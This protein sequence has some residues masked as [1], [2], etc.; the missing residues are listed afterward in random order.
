LGAR[1]TAQQL[2]ALAVFAEAWDS[3]SSIHKAYHLLWSSRSLDTQQSQNTQ[4]YKK[5]KKVFFKKRGFHFLP[6]HK[7][8]VQKLDN[9]HILN[10]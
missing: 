4:T 6:G 10:I 1:E 3:V 2:R 9:K 7:V 8:N 5:K